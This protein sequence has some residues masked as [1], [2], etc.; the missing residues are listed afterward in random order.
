MVRGKGKISGSMGD[1]PSTIQIL[2]SVAYDKYMY[3]NY[4]SIWR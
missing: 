2:K 1:L 3:D 4:Y